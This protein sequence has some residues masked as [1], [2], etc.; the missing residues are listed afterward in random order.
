MLDLGLEGGDDS[1]D[2]DLP[3]DDLVCADDELSD[4]DVLGR[5]GGLPQSPRSR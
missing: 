5:I 1:N 4:S 2:E 3:E